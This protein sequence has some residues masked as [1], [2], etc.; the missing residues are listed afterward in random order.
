MTSR[1]PRHCKPAYGKRLQVSDSA[2]EAFKLPRSYQDHHDHARFLSPARA[3]C[4]AIFSRGLR[5]VPVAREMETAVDELSH[6]A[7]V[8][9]IEKVRML[10]RAGTSPIDRD[11]TGLPSLHRAA[12]GGHTA[13]TTALLEATGASVHS[14]VNVKDSVRPA[15]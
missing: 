1:T 5:I 10:L 8:G 6:A 14:A 7:F 13:I 4:P 15:R 9:D 3:C 2:S 12:I 11:A